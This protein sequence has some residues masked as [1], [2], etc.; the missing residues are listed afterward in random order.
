MKNSI[1][2]YFVLL[3]CLTGF[4]INAQEK[5]T[6]YTDDKLLLMDDYKTLGVFEY[7]DGSLWMI[8]DR[9]I[10]IFDGERW[11]KI[12]SKTNS[13]NKSISSFMVDSKN[14]IWVGSNPDVAYGPAFLNKY[15]NGVVIYDGNEWQSMRTMDMGF[16]AP[17]VTRMF[18]TK[19]GDIWLGVS[20]NKAGYETKNFLAKGALLRL[21]KEEWTVYKAKDVPCLSCEYVKSFYEDENGR[22]YFFAQNG[23]YYFEDGSFHGVKK[24]EGYNLKKS[25]NFMFVD[26]KKNLWVAAYNRAAMYNGREWKSFG[27]K[28]GITSGESLLLGFSETTDGKIIL[29]SGNGYFYY[30]NAGQWQHEKIKFLSGNTY[31]DSQNRLWISSNKGL[32]IKDGE[33]TTMHKDIPWVWNI[34]QDKADGVWA[35]SHKD[36]IKRLKDGQWQLFNKDN[37]LPSDKILSGYVANDGKVWISTSKGVCSCEYD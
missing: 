12:N 15:N 7:E 10:N 16:K 14:R 11:K 13:M 22:L 1:A 24:D 30:D 35:M 5:W 21:S 32:M 9:G 33:E 2:K 25:P 19:N 8:T 4:T 28:N 26:S 6:C 23:L 18:E 36:G 37:Q 27:R 3:F 34:F 29:T 17:V 31:I 20:S